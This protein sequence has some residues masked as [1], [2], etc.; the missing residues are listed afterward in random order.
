MSLFLHRDE[1]Q[2]WWHS[3]L[4]HWS[5]RH[6]RALQCVDFF[7]VT[8]PGPWDWLLSILIRTSLK[9]PFKISLLPYRHF[10]LL[11]SLA[12]IPLY[13]MT[14]RL[15]LFLTVS[16]LIFSRL[17]LRR[18]I[19][20]W[21]ADPSFNGI[22]KEALGT[23]SAFWSHNWFFYWVGPIIR[24]LRAY[25]YICSSYL[26]IFDNFPR[27]QCFVQAITCTCEHDTYYRAQPHQLDFLK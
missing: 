22:F 12:Y 18:I 26:R 11:L 19:W 17:F 24:A 6:S 27:N 20:P 4:S 14:E 8:L 3:L 13:T 23:G 5:R 16:F 9:A 25:S 15:L 2:E 10:S 7:C 1:L 21:G